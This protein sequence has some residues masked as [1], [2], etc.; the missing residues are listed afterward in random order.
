MSATIPPKRAADARRPDA[1][2]A[3]NDEANR[4]AALEGRRLAKPL[5]V[6]VPKAA[7]VLADDPLDDL[8][9]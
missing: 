7:E 2:V 5:E 8:R 1:A 3:S 6:A 4:D 9:R